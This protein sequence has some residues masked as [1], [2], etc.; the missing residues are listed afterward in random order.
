MKKVAAELWRFCYK[1][2]HVM[3]ERQGIFMNQKGNASIAVSAIN[4]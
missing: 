2:T 1:R 4:S 3:L